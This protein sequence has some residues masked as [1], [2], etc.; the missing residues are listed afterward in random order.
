MFQ[1]KQDRRGLPERILGFCVRFV[2]FFAYL[3]AIV[4]VFGVNPS[5]HNPVFIALLFAIPAAWGIWE[6]WGAPKN[7]GFAEALKAETAGMLINDA[8][9][10]IIYYAENSQPI[11]DLIAVFISLTVAYLVFFC[12]GWAVSKTRKPRRPEKA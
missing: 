12:I 3:F 11:T 10:V 7:V 8:F 6:G 5:S 2:I 9:L 1:G 4:Y